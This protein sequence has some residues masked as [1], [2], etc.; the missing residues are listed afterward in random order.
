MRD[1]G[2][3]EKLELG[4]LHAELDPLDHVECEE[5]GFGGGDV[6]VGGFMKSSRSEFSFGGFIGVPG[7]ASG[8]V[9][10]PQAAA[11]MRPT[12]AAMTPAARPRVRRDDALDMRGPYNPAHSP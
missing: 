1:I 11:A 6:G 2:A 9:E 12:S 7:A 4:V 8:G 10:L 5:E 3:P